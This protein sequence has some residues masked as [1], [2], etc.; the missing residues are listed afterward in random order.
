MHLLNKFKYLLIN[1][2]MSNTS[3]STFKIDLSSLTLNNSASQNCKNEA[4]HNK[5][6]NY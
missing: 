1:M 6:V 5:E 2:M 4:N 3:N